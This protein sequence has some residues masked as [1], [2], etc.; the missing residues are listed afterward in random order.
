MYEVLIDDVKTGQENPERVY[1]DLFPAEEAAMDIAAEIADGGY[2]GRTTVRNRHNEAIF[3][4]QV[5]AGLMR[6]ADE[7]LGGDYAYFLEDGTQLV[8]R[9]YR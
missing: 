2:T 1:E 8:H 7:G 4:V 9:N 6:V 5:R 3:T